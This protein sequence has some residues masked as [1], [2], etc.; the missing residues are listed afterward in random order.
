MTSDLNEHESAAAEARERGMAFIVDGKHVNADRIFILSLPDTTG[1]IS[2]MRRAKADALASLQEL[3]QFHANVS[4]PMNEQHVKMTG[5]HLRS[6]M[7]AVGMPTPPAHHDNKYIGMHSYVTMCD[8]ETAVRERMSELNSLIVANNE[9]REIVRSSPKQ[10]Y[11]ITGKSASGVVVDELFD[12]QDADYHVIPA[13]AGPR[14]HGCGL[15][16]V[17]FTGQGWVCLSCAGAKS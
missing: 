17:A 2:D 9:L 6:L 8:I 1:P 16:G 4:K 5:E 13:G 15:C 14:V 12:T 10:L 3:E 7:K 11:S